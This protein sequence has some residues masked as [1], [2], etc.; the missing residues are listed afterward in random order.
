M[1]NR[2]IF[3]NFTSFRIDFKIYHSKI[4][5]EEL[6][7]LLESNS[8]V[9]HACS[10]QFLQLNSNAALSI[11]KYSTALPIYRPFGQLKESR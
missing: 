5:S 3:H 10:V 4:M 1:V 8:T 2:E 11:D 6:V 7:M 9:D